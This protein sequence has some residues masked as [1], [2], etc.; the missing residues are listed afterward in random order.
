MYLHPYYYIEFTWHFG[1]LVLKK[2]PWDLMAQP[3]VKMLEV[4]KSEKRLCCF[5]IIPKKNIN[6]FTSWSHFSTSPLAF[7]GIILITSSTFSFSADSMCVISFLGLNVSFAIPSK[8]FF[9]CGWTLSGSFVSERISMS[10]SLDR[11]KNLT[12]FYREQ[13]N[14]R[15]EQF[16]WHLNKCIFNKHAQLK[17]MDCLPWKE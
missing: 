11:K 3:L 17:K 14:K 7:A 5:K 12:G 10:S 9:R 15:K 4:I 6:L 13:E 2:V 8:H 1:R 16:E